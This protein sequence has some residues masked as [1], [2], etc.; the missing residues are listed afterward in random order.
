MPVAHG[1]W[2]DL[3]IEKPA[4]GGRMIARHEGQ[5]VLVSGAIPGERVRARVERADRRVAF[6]TAVDILEPHP[7]RRPAADWTCGGMTYAFIA[8]ERQL[9]LKAEIIAD[10]FARLGGLPLAR[11]VSVRPSPEQGY[12]M[13]ARLHVAD[14]RVGFYRELTH[15]LCDPAVTG[16]LRPETCRV[17]ERLSRHLRRIAREAVL[18][19]ELAENLGATE[20]AV[21]LQLRPGA[22]IGW[23]SLATVAGLDGVTGASYQVGPG[24]P[25]VRLGGRP[26][27]GDPLRALLGERLAGRAR[28]DRLD[29]RLER[30]AGAF[31]QA[32]RYL[33]P[34]LVEAVVSHAGEEGRIVDLYAGVGLFAAA[35]AALGRDDVVAVEADRVAAADLERNAARLGGAI[36]VRREP[37]ERYLASHA[38]PTPFALILDPPRTG[39][40][41]AALEGAVQHGTHRLLYVSCDAPTL[42]RDARRIVDAGYELAHLE[43]FDLF[44]NTPHVELLAVF[45]RRNAR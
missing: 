13:R 6:A 2:L 17:V 43:A 34:S 39:L 10:A 21:H 44:P 8:Y 40:S 4:A 16:Q 7:D 19:V 32:N 35:L 37:V 12:R 45:D 27:V 33:L 28:A 18:A 20:R 5:V 36:E 30:H 38:G 42:A 41:R 11:P 22:G 29:V 9:A 14:G 24:A 23:A 25:A 1:E 15:D 26:W 31:F 3:T